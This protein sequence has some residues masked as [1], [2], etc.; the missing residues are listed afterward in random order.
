MN[1]G[2]ANVWTL[3][4][5]VNIIW[6]NVQTSESNSAILFINMY[7][8]NSCFLWSIRFVFCVTVKTSHSIFSK[9]INT[10]CF[11]MS[12]WHTVFV[13]I[14][15]F[16]K[17]DKFNK[18]SGKPEKHAKWNKMPSITA[19]RARFTFIKLRISI[20]LWV[21]PLTWRWTF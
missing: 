19:T 9:G 5:H 17:F 14:H 20:N 8:Y 21:L 13:Y 15:S 11:V 4:I 3:N 16:V 18:N 6:I 7:L 2:T 1:F 10:N 12:R